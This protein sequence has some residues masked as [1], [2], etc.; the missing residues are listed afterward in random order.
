MSYSD[1][2]NYS[3]GSLIIL[4]VLFWFVCKCISNPPYD[5]HATHS[6][7]SESMDGKKYRY[8]GSPINIDNQSNLTYMRRTDGVIQV[9]NS[10]T[11]VRHLS[12]ESHDY[13]SVE[14]ISENDN[15]P[16]TMHMKKKNLENKCN[17]PKSL[18][19]QRVH[20]PVDHT[21]RMPMPSY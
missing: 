1:E 17:Q 2:I 20:Q 3:L 10:M 5:K 6:M 12:N 14:N 21:D 7:K 4:L 16:S 13:A 9:P 18:T 8:G 11:S 15:E 19:A